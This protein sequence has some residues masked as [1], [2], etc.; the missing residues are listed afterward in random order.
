MWPLHRAYAPTARWRTHCGAGRRHCSAQVTLLSSL[1]K[2]E[3]LSVADALEPASFSATEVIMKQGDLG[4]A[5]YII[6]EGECSVTRT[7][8]QGQTG[9]VN[10]LK[11]ADYFGAYETLR[12]AFYLKCR[13]PAA[14]SLRAFCSNWISWCGVAM[15]PK[16]AHVLHVYALKFCLARDLPARN[17]ARSPCWNQMESA[18]LQSRR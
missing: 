15:P 18:W 11:V 4:D 6:E 12:R 14:S 1:D 5:F 13:V 17:Q 16:F 2:W 3:R 9:K 10:D 7:N 8:E